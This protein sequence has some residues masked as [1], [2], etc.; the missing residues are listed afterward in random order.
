M[1]VAISS[2]CFSDI[3]FAEAC[4]QIADLHYDKLELW[5]DDASEH[6]K[7]SYVADNPERFV[8]HYREATRLTPVAISL[9]QDLPP[10]PF[11]SICKL[12]K[13]LKI[14]QITIPAGALGTPFNEEIDRLRS[15]Q[16][17]ASTSGIRLSLK[18]KTSTLTEDPRTAVE[19]CQSVQGLGITLDPSA[20]IC[21][22]FSN[23]SIDPVFPYTYHTHLRDTS[24]TQLQIPVGLGEVDYNRIISQLQRCNYTRALSVEMYPELIT[25]TD[26]ALELRK[27]RMLLESLL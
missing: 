1:F 5:M 19:L 22:P 12:A 7:S 9:E 21:G 20:V 2:R 24:P 26:R 27:M 13:I 6:L 14:T 23:Q 16:A 15:R 11:E 8:K 3:S 17:I 18:M 4:S 10:G 25:D